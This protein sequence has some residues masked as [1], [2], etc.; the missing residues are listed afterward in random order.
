MSAFKTLKLASSP[1][2]E[3]AATLAR[4]VATVA[5]K[6][7]PFIDSLLCVIEEVEKMQSDNN[8]N[9]H[10]M[11]IINLLV[12]SISSSLRAVKKTNFV[13]DEEH[14]QTTLKKLGDDII[15]AAKFIKMYMSTQWHNKYFKAS[16]YTSEFEMLSKKLL[17]GMQ[18]LH[19]EFSATEGKR[20]KKLTEDI[21]TKLNAAKSKD[22]VA[23][24]MKRVEEEAKETKRNL[25]IAQ[26]LLQ[27]QGEKNAEEVEK[28]AEEA[29]A[30]E[31]KLQAADA[32][33]KEAE[34]MKA[35]VEA[36]KDEEIAELKK[37]LEES[38]KQSEE[39]KLEQE[40]IMKE[41]EEALEK[42]RAELVRDAENRAGG[43]EEG[44]EEEEEEEQHEDAF[45]ATLDKIVAGDYCPP[46]ALKLLKELGESCRWGVSP[47]GFVLDCEL[48]T[49]IFNLLSEA[50][51]LEDIALQLEEHGDQEG[52][53]EMDDKA[54]DFMRRVTELEDHHKGIVLPTASSLL[55]AIER[56]LDWNDEAKRALANA[57]ADEL[58]AKNVVVKEKR[59]AAAEAEVKWRA[60]RKST[61]PEVRKN[62][63]QLRK[64]LDLANKAALEAE[65]N[66]GIFRPDDGAEAEK[67]RL[68]NIEVIRAILVTA[69]QKET[70]TKDLDWE[71]TGKEPV[72]KSRDTGKEIWS[73]FR[74]FAK[75]GD[76]E[77]EKAL[78]ASLKEEL[79]ESEREERLQYMETSLALIGLPQADFERKLKGLEC[80]GR[81]IVELSKALI[82]VKYEFKGSFE[83]KLKRTDNDIKQ[84]VRE[85]CS[86]RSAA[87]E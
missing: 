86:S 26:E 49:T 6:S 50:T 16:A 42:K 36:A 52:A 12:T 46:E 3:S 14:D 40:K 37:K 33:I 54:E 19:F 38:A 30:M 64:D 55:F 82:G 5:A 70:E 74:R 83:E 80:R 2:I 4:V 69:E 47:D 10:M 34:A 59:A 32:K 8:F 79:S 29:R 13:D 66:V 17:Y 61:D 77:F 76:V 43:E 75:R 72:E 56:M 85:W 1:A 53:D 27:S 18:C 60:A 57:N 7:I 23:E 65:F 84:A 25:E 71:K 81:Q 15:H 48:E 20:N 28:K 22:E 73:H 9:S 67:L 68:Q 51:K 21:M 62:R 35:Q 31:E 58:V 39:E 63:K 41:R 45:S 11:E 24:A 78:L 44:K 87:E